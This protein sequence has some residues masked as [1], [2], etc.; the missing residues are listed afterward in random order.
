MAGEET[1]GERESSMKTSLSLLLL[2]S[3]LSCGTIVKSRVIQSS[4]ETV[5]LE[6]NSAVNDYANM[7]KLAEEEA[8]K[9]GKRAVVRGVVN[10][11]Q[12]SAFGSIDTVVF[13]LQ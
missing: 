8:K 6:Y 10:S 12:Q 5:T 9:Y 1:R 7:V 11:R 4:P 3:C 13:D 2:F